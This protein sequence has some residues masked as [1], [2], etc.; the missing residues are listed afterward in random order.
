MDLV[1]ELVQAV[2]VS[3]GKHFMVELS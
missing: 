1:D 3:Y 2:P